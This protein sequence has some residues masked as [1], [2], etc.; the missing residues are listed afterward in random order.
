MNSVVVEGC[1]PGATVIVQTDEPSPV[2]VAKGTAAGGRDWLPVIGTLKAKQRLVAFQAVPGD[3]SPITPSDLAVTVSVSPTSHAQLPPLSFISKLYKCGRAVWLKGAAPGAVVS[4]ASAGTP[5]GSGRADQDGNARFGVAP[6]LP[7][8]NVAVTGSQAAPP[9][10]PPLAGTPQKITRN[11]LPAPF[12][13]LPSPNVNQPLPMGCESSIRISGVIDG[14]EV[15]VERAS[16]GTLDIAVFDLDG[17]WFNLSKPFP[18]T[19]D[20]ILIRQSLAPRCH[21]YPSDPREEKIGPAKPPDALM[22]DEPCAGSVLVHVEKVR[23]GAKLRVEVPGT[24]PL[25]YI[26]PPGTTVWDV[27]VQPLPANQ[28]VQI[29]M[30]IC[31]FSTSHGCDQG[32]WRSYSRG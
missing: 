22:V 4:V 20:R 7:G 23:P 11:T 25:D 28:T 8:P 18:P 24:T 5:L 31:G 2:V 21:E 30:E 10:F 1:I 26:V 16:D 13:K 27:P 3:T 29:T 14:A 15:T 12:G 9:S 19:G 6:F 17:L 32:S